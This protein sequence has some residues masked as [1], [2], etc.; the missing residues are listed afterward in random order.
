[1]Q[2]T[3]Y[4]GLACSL[5]FK[6]FE[7]N[8]KLVPYIPSYSLFLN[9]FLLLMHTKKWQTCLVRSKIEIQAERK[10]K[11]QRNLKE[12]IQRENLTTSH[13]NFNLN[14]PTLFFLF[15]F[16]L[17]KHHNFVGFKQEGKTRIFI[18]IY[19]FHSPGS[20]T[21]FQFQ[22]AFL[23]VNQFNF[24]GQMFSPSKKKKRNL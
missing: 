19:C 12:N 1:M 17:A 14:S 2:I 21:S 20:K 10:R 11:K 6:G 9:I 24:G 4:E 5:Y 16:F 13:R 7:D 22:D 15:S 3:K 23:K 8:W 18:S